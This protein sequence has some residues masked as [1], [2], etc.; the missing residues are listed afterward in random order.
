MLYF[1]TEQEI[2]DDWLKN[3]YHLLFRGVSI[4][5]DSAHVSIDSATTAHLIQ[6]MG[7]MRSSDYSDN[8]R[9]QLVATFKGFCLW[10]ADTDRL[11]GIDAARIARVKLPK[12]QWKCKTADDLLTKA[13]VETVLKACTNSRDRALLAMCYDGSDRPI[14][15]LS[16][17]WRDIV[18]DE[19]GAYFLTAQKTG[20]RRKIRLTFS[21]PHLG[22]WR[23][24]YPGIPAGDAPVFCTLNKRAG[25]YIQMSKDALDRRVKLIREE[26]GIP[27]L[28]PSIFRPTRISHDVEDGYELSYI[29]LKNW[30]NLKTPMIDR[31]TSVSDDYIDRVALER[32]GL[33][34]PEKKDKINPLTPQVCPHCGTVNPSYAK[35]C[36][37]CLRPLTTDATEVIEDAKRAI[38]GDYET[39]QAVFDKMFEEK[40]KEMGRDR[41]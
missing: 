14:E 16:L 40:M 12:P 2:S 19:W 26:T 30:G 1:Q 35:I 13:E 15:I 24:D 31:Y 33:K 4:L 7:A 6:V 28:M 36:A 37:F 25:K 5:H 41:A 32:A 29:M 9:R 20:R 23:E 17:K 34:K 8:Y 21:L 3:K 11:P 27:K 22:Q 18:F 38:T 10:L 39:M